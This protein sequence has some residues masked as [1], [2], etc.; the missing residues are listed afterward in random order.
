M[1]CLSRAPIGTKWAPTCGGCVRSRAPPGDHHLLVPPATCKS[2]TR[3]NV[4]M[5]PVCLHLDV[6]RGPASGCLCDHATPKC[7]CREYYNLGHWERLQQFAAK[8]NFDIQ[9]KGPY[10]SEAH[11][12]DCR[13]CTTC[14]FCRSAQRRAHPESRQHSIVVP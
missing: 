10:C 7:D 2:Y 12:P 14:H 13:D 4:C 9:A 3:H 1:Q 8:R 6:H 11:G 5:T